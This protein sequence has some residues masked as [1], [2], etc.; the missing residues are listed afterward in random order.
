MHLDVA[1]NASNL[2]AEYG[3][4][5]ELSRRQAKV[6]LRVLP[7]GASTVWG[8]VSEPHDGRRDGFRKPFRDALRTAA[9]GVNMVGTQNGGMNLDSDNEGHPGYKVAGINRELE[10]S[11]PFKPNL[12]LIQA[13]TNDGRENDADSDHVKGVGKE[14][15]DMIMKIYNEPDMDRTCVLSSTLLW[16]GQ[17]DHSRKSINNQYRD[18]VDDLKDEGKCIF[19]ADQDPDE[20]ST[21][22]PESMIGDG[23]HPS[24][25]GFK[26]M[27]AVF[28]KAFE[29]ATKGNSLVPSVNAPEIG[30]SGCEKNPGQRKSVGQNTQKGAAGENDGIYKHKSEKMDVK[31]TIKS[32]NDLNQ[33]RFGKLFG[34]ESDK[35]VGWYEQP[36]GNHAFGVWKSNGDGSFDKVDDMNPDLFCKPAGINF[37]D[38]NGDGHGDM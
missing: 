8:I 38:M 12:V 15:R 24:T 6:P 13:G 17:N 14:M 18:L 30:A 3:I 22:I 26:K 1:F 37:I 23:I 34:R 31:T 20:K 29:L 9:W 33:Y 28:D 32:S 36:N 21:W 16:S 27:A 35:L 2:L 4:D 7:L 11:L 5:L 25:E 19:L 10:N